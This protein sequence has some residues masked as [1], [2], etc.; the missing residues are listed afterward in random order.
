MSIPRSQK[1]SILTPPHPIPFLWKFWSSLHVI[2]FSLLNYWYGHE[3]FRTTHYYA[4]EKEKKIDLT[5][6]LY[7]NSCTI[8]LKIAQGIISPKDIQIYKVYVPTFSGVY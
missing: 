4:L 6:F 2:H 7:G 3:F 8:P 1:A 5:Q